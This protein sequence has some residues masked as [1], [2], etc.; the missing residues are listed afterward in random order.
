MNK[1]EHVIKE[2]DDETALFMKE[3]REQEMRG[4]A[5]ERRNTLLHA[6]LHDLPHEV[7]IDHRTLRRLMQRHNQAIGMLREFLAVHSEDS[8]LVKRVHKLVDNPK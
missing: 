5:K 4:E 8:D 7:Q 2:F 3:M 1:Y 6:L